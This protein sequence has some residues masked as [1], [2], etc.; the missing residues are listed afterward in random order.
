MNILIINTNPIFGGAKSANIAIATMLSFAHNVVV[1]DEFSHSQEVKGTFTLDNTPI[2]SMNNNQ[3]YNYVKKLKVDCVIWGIMMMAPRFLFAINKL[4]KD[5]IKQIMVFH[6]LSIGKSLKSH[7]MER[8]VCLSSC[9]MDFLCFVSKYTQESWK[10]YKSIK[11]QKSKFVIIPNAIEDLNSSPRTLQNKYKIGFVGRLSQEKRPQDFC[12]VAQHCN[13]SQ[14]S[15]ELWGDGPMF[16]K[17]SERYGKKVIFHGYEE[18]INKIYQNID[19][20]LM[21]S[22]FENCPMAILEAKMRGIPCIVPKVG[23]IPEIHTSYEGIL[24]KTFNSENILKDI[25]DIIKLY[26]TFSER[27]IER[28]RNYN[29]TNISKYWETLIDNCLRN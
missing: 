12:E 26:P 13:N 27:S 5:G 10:K 3:F 15:F 23:G 21:T 20:L 24:Y 17:L 18:N 8:L 9:Q 25:E 29:Y 28:A 1:N 2:K 4:K 19:I 11:K 14:Y 7:L 6:S 22:E 16:D